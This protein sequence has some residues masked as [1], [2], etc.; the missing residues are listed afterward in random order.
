VSPGFPID[1]ETSMQELG[2]PAW[3]WLNAGVLIV[4]SAIVWIK[5]SMSRKPEQLTKLA[6]GTATAYRPV[7]AP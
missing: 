1:L 7:S 6:D 5:L 2:I 3:I 4:A